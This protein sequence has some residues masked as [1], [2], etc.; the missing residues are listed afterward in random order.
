MQT[1]DS[2]Q[3][4]EMMK[5]T[6]TGVAEHKKSTSASAEEQKTDDDSKVIALW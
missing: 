5:I 4:D 2:S 6:S 1:V 3:E